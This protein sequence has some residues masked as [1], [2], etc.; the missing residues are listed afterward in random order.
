MEVPSSIFY[1]FAIAKKT[2]VPY[3]MKNKIRYVAKIEQRTVVKFF[4]PVEKA[5]A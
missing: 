2:P 5:V 3:K 4:L 1:A